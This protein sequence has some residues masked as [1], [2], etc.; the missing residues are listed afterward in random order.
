MAKGKVT[1]S[2][3]ENRR[4]LAVKTLISTALAY[5][6]GSLAIDSGSYWHYLLAVIAIVFA[7]KFVARFFKK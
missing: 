5:I 1:V 6:F 2:Y 7:V 4:I 3:H